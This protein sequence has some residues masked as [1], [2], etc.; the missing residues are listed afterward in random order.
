MPLAEASAAPPD[1]DPGG[2]APVERPMPP[3]GIAELVEAARLGDHDAFGSLVRATYADTYT[4]AVR[5]TGDEEDARDVVQEAYLRAFRGLQ[6]FR[7][8]AQFSTWMYR[9]TAN[10]ASTHLG[11]RRRHRH[12]A[13]ADEAQVVDLHVDHDPVL[14]ADLGHLRAQLADALRELPPRLR[15]VVVLRDVYD[16]THEDIA[17]ELGISESAAKVRLHRARRKLREHLVPRRD[18]DEPSESARAVS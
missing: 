15:A 16:L 9:I 14:R 2:S 4:L 18:G 5:L 1:G 3:D 10:C 8:D 12:E 17:A 11:R 6:R 7:G 13:L